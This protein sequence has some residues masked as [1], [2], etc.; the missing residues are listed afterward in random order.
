MDTLSI[1]TSIAELI[2]PAGLVIDRTYK[3]TIACKNAE[4][5][6][7]AFGRNE[8]SNWHPESL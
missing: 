4:R 8:R 3:T 7:E 6:T 5:Y 2:T 1:T